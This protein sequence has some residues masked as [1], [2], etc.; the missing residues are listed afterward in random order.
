MGS[1]A[2]YEAPG[3][4]SAGKL[5]QTEC[6]QAMRAC[7]LKW[8]TALA[9]ACE[10]TSKRVHS[11]SGDARKAASGVGAGASSPSAC[12]AAPRMPPRRLRMKQ[13]LP[14]PGA[15]TCSEWCRRQGQDEDGRSWVVACQHSSR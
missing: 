11:A 8:N 2:P 14:S 3:T 1:R 6:S 12:A 15:P 9:S 5:S 7:T 10:A 13:L 4:H